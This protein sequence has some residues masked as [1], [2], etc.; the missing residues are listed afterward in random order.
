MGNSTQHSM[1]WLP[2]TL[3]QNTTVLTIN[4]KWGKE[5]AS[6]TTGA[7]LVSWEDTMGMRCLWLAISAL[8]LNT[9]IFLDEYLILCLTNPII[10]THSRF[11][12]G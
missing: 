3:C 4:D 11:N 9:P 1:R 2:K 7:F 8:Y 6:C 5:N 12:I 10:R